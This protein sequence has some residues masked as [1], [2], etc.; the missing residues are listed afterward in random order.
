M[1]KI[2]LDLL[3]VERGLAESRAKA[4]AIIMAGQVRVNGQVADKAST[5]FMTDVQV[6]VD[7]GPRFVSRGGEKLLG[8]LETFAIDPRG[9]TCADVGASTGGFSDCLLQHGATKVYAIDV[10]KGILHWKLRTDP[11]VVVM[12]ET[13]ARFVESLPEPVQLVVCDASFISLKILLPVIKAWLL[14]QDNNQ[15]ESFG[16]VALIKPQFE[17]GRKESAKHKGVIRDPQIH[18]RILRDVIEFALQTG[19]G[20]RGL[21]KSPLLGPKGNVEFLAWF[22]LQPNQ[23]QVAV[24]VNQLTG[25]I[26]EEDPENSALSVSPKTST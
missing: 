5:S 22:D 17:A 16:L 1:K 4:Q 23:A 15:A 3:L 10:G 6:D 9:L 25:V 21:E 24:L 7:S 26:E 19:Y 13:N 20:L 8:A 2:R 14:H 18:A 12:E 11:R